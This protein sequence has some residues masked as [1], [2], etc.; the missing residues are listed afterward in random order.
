MGAPKRVKSKTT[1][2]TRLSR[3]LLLLLRGANRKCLHHGCRLPTTLRSPCSVFSIST[4]VSFAP[5][6]SFGCSPGPFSSLFLYCLSSFCFFACG[7]SIMGLYVACKVVWSTA[8]P[9]G[10]CIQCPGLGIQSSGS[11]WDSR[12]T[13]KYK[14]QHHCVLS[15]PWVPICLCAGLH[16]HSSSAAL[17]W[18]H[19]NTASC[20][21]IAL[22]A[23]LVL[24]YLLIYVLLTYFVTFWL[25][26]RFLWFSFTS[27]PKKLDMI[28]GLVLDKETQTAV[29]SLPLSGD[30]NHCKLCHTF[31]FLPRLEV[32]FKSRVKSKTF[33]ELN[34]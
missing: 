9:V 15:L 26:L 20:G 1:N 13:V 6:L 12:P 11:L 23:Q 34:F 14:P 33:Q 27:S 3:I 32:Q 2:T 18:V 16:P 7:F 5:P 25:V 17:G 8:L 4:E 30:L 24:L 22:C 31:F 10:L 29:T 19:A 21:T 28:M